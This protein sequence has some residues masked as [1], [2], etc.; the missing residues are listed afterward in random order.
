MEY[1]HAVHPTHADN[2]VDHF[3]QIACSL[4]IW[5]VIRHSQDRE[6]F[7]GRT[8][9]IR[10]NELDVTAVIGPQKASDGNWNIYFL[11]SHYPQLPRFIAVP[12]SAAVTANFVNVSYLYSSRWYL[13]E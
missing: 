3:V 11:F 6:L 5:V 12:H 7:P 9:L 2:R 1:Y 4:F 8:I 10:V 13:T